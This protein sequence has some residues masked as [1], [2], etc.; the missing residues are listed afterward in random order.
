MEEGMIAKW[1]KKEGDQVHPG[2]LLMEVATDKATVEH[3]ALDGGWIRGILVKEGEMA[4]VN[5]AIAIMTEGQDESIEG[6]KPEG[7]E[8]K[9]AP[10]PQTD[11]NV[12]EENS[13]PASPQ[14]S[15]GGLVQPAFVPEEPLSDY[16]FDRPT[17][18]IEQRVLASP[19]AKKI[20]KEQ[21][22]D[23]T[24]VKGTGPNSRV[25][26]KDLEKAHPVGAV[27]F[28]NREAP[29]IKP[30][31]YEE[32][33]LTPMRKVIG[34]RLQEAKT[35]IPH[36]YISQTCNAE[37]L[38]EIREQLRNVEI[39]L[40]FNDFV[41]KACALALKQHPTVNSGF[42]SVNNAIIHFKTI[43]IAVA[44]TVN[45]GLI[46]PI[47]RHADYKNVAEISSEVRYL[48]KQAKAGKL[49]PYEYKGG[50]FTVSN[51]GMFGVTDFQAII[52]PPQAAI[53]AISGIQDTPVV[54]KGVV[55]PGK[56]MNIT[57]SADHRVVDGVAGAEFIKTVQRFLEN[58]ASLLIS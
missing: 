37:P 31:T 16:I 38:H 35:F 58:P 34:Q 47:I 6:Y 30:G 15:V 20:A 14:K 19:L 10:Q 28:G 44:V 50:S 3:N 46:T 51:L 39:K 2:D 36:F 18:L 7:V 5:Q 57:L 26:S 12:E 27:S 21:G 48:S 24:S 32:E 22:L 1:H 29:S 8:K 49:E 17:D 55:V 41:I 11:Q 56:T 43:D 45:G 25:T 23:I 40:T 9:Q 4:Q 53:L 42:N 13:K 54:R 33:L 52:N